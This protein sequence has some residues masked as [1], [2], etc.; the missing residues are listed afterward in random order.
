MQRRNAVF[1]VRYIFTCVLVACLIIFTSASSDSNASP[2]INSISGTVSDGQTITI[3][4]S[5]FGIVGPNVILFDDFETGINN[6]YIGNGVT[7]ARVGTWE[8]SSTACSPT[9]YSIYS[10][11][12]AHSGTKSAR[13]NWAK[14]PTADG[15]AMWIGPLFNGP[16]TKIY[17]SFWTYLPTG[18]NVPGSSG[19]MGPNWK[20]WWLQSTPYHKDDFASEI[21]TDPPYETSLCWVDGTKNRLCYMN[22]YQPF[23]FSKG[24]WKR[25]EVY[26]TASTSSGVGQ[27]W[28]TSA[29][30]AR[31]LWANATGRTIDDG[32]AGWNYLRMP[33]YARYDS[34]SNTYYDDIYVATGNGALARVEIGNNSSY[35]N[36]TNLAVITPTAW[37]N[38]SITATVRKGAFN[39]GNAAY[40]FVIDSTGAASPGYPVTIGSGG[41]APTPAT[42]SAPTGLRILTN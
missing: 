12:Q 9:Y 11:S 30:Q 29:A 35:T 38:A 25:W 10:T 7:P 4:G 1:K 21:V 39:P 24:Q 23:S 2:A 17:F 27:L 36:C 16:V 28:F 37:S 5:G 32:S 26:M 31:S 13:Q 22:S 33:G 15:G 6:N 41:S 20:V 42:V 3:N 14:S 34:N 18:Q 40:L 19:G 8:D